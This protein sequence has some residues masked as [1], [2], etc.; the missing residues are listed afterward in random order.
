VRT[1]FRATQNAVET[2]AL[3]TGGEYVTES[4]LHQQRVQRRSRWG[5][6]CLFLLAVML[7]ALLFGSWWNPHRVVVSHTKTNH[8]VAPLATRTGLK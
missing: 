6:V 1:S 3:L 2:K 7:R 8:S 5:T 4:T